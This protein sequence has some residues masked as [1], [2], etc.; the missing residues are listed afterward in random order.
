M[1]FEKQDSGYKKL[2]SQK[3]TLGD[4]PFNSS[5]AGPKIRRRGQGFTL[6]ELLAVMFI[7]LLILVLSLSWLGRNI[8]YYKFGSA[9]GAFKSAVNLARMRSMGDRGGMVSTIF[10]EQI[11]AASQ[12][13]TLTVGKDPYASTGPATHKLTPGKKYFVG[14]IGFAPQDTQ[15]EF[16]W[17][18][19]DRVC[20]CEVP[21]ETSLKCTLSDMNPV[22]NPNPMPLS[23]CAV[24]RVATVIR[25]TGFAPGEV[26]DPITKETMGFTEFARVSD[27]GTVLDFYFNTDRIKTRFLE[28]D[29]SG[30]TTEIDCKDGGCSVVFDFHGFTRNAGSYDISFE[31][32]KSKS[33]YVQ[34]ILPSGALR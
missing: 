30:N 3:T 9:M 19:N 8:R 28:T 26:I 21:N 6:I 33:A 27:N 22:L 12:V 14:F 15:Q 10:I 25:L 29:E 20:E 7:G 13:L 2:H 23:D 31:D 4:G 16:P 17:S 1:K 24:A 34:K 18:I 11:A 5:E 32:V